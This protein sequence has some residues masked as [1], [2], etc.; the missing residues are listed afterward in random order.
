MRVQLAHQTCPPLTSA[1]CVRGTQAGRGYVYS[2]NA[3]PDAPEIRKPR[4]MSNTDVSPLA[5]TP[6]I[7]LERASYG[8]PRR[9]CARPR[10]QPL[11]V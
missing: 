4:S 5:L 2:M 1:G 10:A 7:V 8:R 9:S 11:A 3:T 6:I